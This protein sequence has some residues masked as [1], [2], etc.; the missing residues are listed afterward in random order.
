M[1]R[2]MR[3]PKRG[4]APRGGAPR[5]E[6]T[7]AALRKYSAAFAVSATT[8]TTTTAKLAPPPPH[9][10]GVLLCE[11]QLMPRDAPRALVRQSRAASPPPPPR[12]APPPPRRYRARRPDRR[13]LVDRLLPSKLEAETSLKR[14]QA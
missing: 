8:T 4:G 12:S 11:L 9:L 7:Q 10:L 5:V 1:R 6:G 3:R 13:H 2:R 14:R